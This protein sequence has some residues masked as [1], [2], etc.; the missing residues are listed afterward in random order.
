MMS[1]EA[2]LSA[3]GESDVSDRLMQVEQLR[4]RARGLAGVLAERKRSL[5]RDHGQLLDAGVVAN[6]EADAARFRTELDEVTTALERVVPNAEA[7]AAEEE[8]F[9]TERENITTALAA[10]DGG[11]K[12]ASAAAEV[13]GELRSIRNG[14]ER[15]E[16]ELSRATTHGDELRAQL[17]RLADETER[18]RSDC[19]QA[20]SVETP[21]VD[22]IEAAEA[23]RLAADAASERCRPNAQHAAE[24]ASRWRARV[25]ALQTGARRR[26]CARRR[27]AARWGRRRARYAARP[28]RDRCRLARSRRG[29]ARRGADRSRRRRIPPRP[30]GR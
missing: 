15:S 6:L 10:D 20:E 21:L 11:A 13:R 26:P 4:E 28:D 8:A 17:S 14:V 18:L 7:L 30:S 24:A 1:L 12:A 27:R 25:E 19:A 9:R 23:A 3:R 16:S 22:Q 5:E 2:Q 29:V